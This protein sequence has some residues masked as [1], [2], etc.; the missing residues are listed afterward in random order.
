MLTYIGLY[1]ILGVEVPIMYIYVFH[2]F[3]IVLSVI[4][5]LC[6]LETQGVFFLYGEQNMA[7]MESFVG[8]IQICDKNINIELGN[9]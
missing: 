7:K 1:A 8:K 9:V 4:C 3:S 5:S 6:Y 2:I